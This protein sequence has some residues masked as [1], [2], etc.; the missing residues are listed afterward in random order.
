MVG[1]LGVHAE[2]DRLVLCGQIR[3]P[4]WPPRRSIFTREV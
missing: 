1:D 4:L 2:R 3:E